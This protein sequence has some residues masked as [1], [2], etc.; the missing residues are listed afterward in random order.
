MK[1]A[2][3]IFCLL[4]LTIGM[5]NAQLSDTIY[6]STSATVSLLF[7]DPITLADVGSDEYVFEYDG[8]LLLLKAKKPHAKITSLLVRYGDAFFTGAIGY[9]AHPDGFHYDYRPTVELPFVSSGESPT[10][11]LVL[12]DPEI[13]SAPKEIAQ[14]S[15]L[16]RQQLNTLKQISFEKARVK[17][18][19]KG[20]VFGVLEVVRNSDS[21]TFIRIRLHNTSTMPF[22]L[23][24]SGLQY[25]ERSKGKGLDDMVLPMK[26]C[27]V[28]LPDIVQPID[29]AICLFA[30][31]HFATSKH[32]K[33]EV[34]IQESKGTR[35]VQLAIPS[36]YVLHAPTL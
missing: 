36:R 7:P 15:L 22:E 13:A 5:V 2:I 24:F 4:S 14:D 10:D 20:G 33:L 23:Q 11:L 18:R 25:R 6:T 17:S 21:C 28:E 1:R 26:P 35:A 8:N 30:I 34:N 3:S 9:Q 12:P 16:L 27:L 19:K 31:P 29:Q 32:A